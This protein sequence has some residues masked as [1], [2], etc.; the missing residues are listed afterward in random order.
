MSPINL[1]RHW[2]ALVVVSVALYVGPSCSAQGSKAPATCTAAPGVL[3]AKTDAGWKSIGPGDAV[4][5]KTPLVSLFYSVLKSA[6]GGVEVVLAADPA[7][8]GPLPILE[9][10][11]LLH[12]DAKHDLALSPLRGLIVMKNVKKDGPAVIEVRRDSDSAEVTLKEPGAMLAME[13]YSRHA[14][15]KPKL[16]PKQDEP[17]VH[18][19]LIAVSGEV[20]LR[21]GDKGWTLH[22]PPGPAVLVWDSLLRQPEIQ[23]LEEMPAEY[24]ALKTD[25]KMLDEACACCAKLK[26][27]AHADAL[28][29]VAASKESLERKAAVIA[30]GALDELPLLLDTLATTP[31]ADARDTAIL[32][33]RHWLGRAPGQTVKLYAA[34]VT[35]G[36]SV[37]Q[38]QT[39]LQLLCGFTPD[40]Q[41][42]PDTYEVLVDNLKH[43]KAAVRALS[44][45]HLVRLASPGKSIAYDPQAPEADLHRAY[46]QWRE[47]I[48]VGKLPPPPPK[49]GADSR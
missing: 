1:R 43:T 12:D 5:A 48:P 45:W 13:I 23:R 15:G 16:D 17:V 41:G 3:V 33:L 22:A 4:P 18:L 31:H 32:A 26:A 38:S 8:R 47:L 28:K 49:A 25:K 20:F 36:Y 9:S 7:Q 35:A 42:D 19:F 30:M 34:L 24:K 2:P 6:N 29:T 46:K 10:A 37:P 21:H 44:H 11:V 40:Q 14:P 27:K 39:V